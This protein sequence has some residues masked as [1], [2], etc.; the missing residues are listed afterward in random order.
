[1][2]ITAARIERSNATPQE[3]YENAA[4]RVE[5]QTVN[6]VAVPIRGGRKKAEPPIEVRCVEC[7]GIC[8]G[9]VLR[10]SRCRRACYCSAACQRAAWPAHKKK[11]AAPRKTKGLCAACGR[12]DEIDGVGPIVA[13]GATRTPCGDCGRVASGDPAEEVRLLRAL[14]EKAPSG[15]HAPLAYALVGKFAFDAA[16]GAKPGSSEV[17]AFE[18]EAQTCLT[19]SADAGVGASAAALG[20]LHYREAMALQK[21]DEEKRGTTA[22]AEGGATAPGV[23]AALNVS[24]SWYMR[25]L[26]GTGPYRLTDSERAEI[27]DTPYVRAVVGAARFKA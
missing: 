6:G 26:E 24:R 23:A 4:A 27:A 5:T 11:C 21:A 16:A 17:G 19:R 14:V 15:P 8:E 20:Q 10:C 12:V 7:R 25:A 22:P 13:V 2:P 18:R 3:S 1:M 9:A